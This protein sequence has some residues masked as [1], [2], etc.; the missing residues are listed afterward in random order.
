MIVQKE[1]GG[2]TSMDSGSLMKAR[3]RA[4]AGCAASEHAI[5]AHHCRH[6][7]LGKTRAFKVAD[8][9]LHGLMPD[10]LGS[11]ECCAKR[12]VD[13][14][15]HEVLVLRVEVPGAQPRSGIREVAQQ[16][17]VQGGELIDEAGELLALA[18]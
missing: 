2:S 16:P 6:R 8:G 13:T 17:D 12:A 3:K 1:S 9:L 7:D 18:R 11:V 14:A 5:R 10:V 15:H 4:L